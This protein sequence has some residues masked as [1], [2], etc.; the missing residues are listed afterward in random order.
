[1]ADKILKG[2]DIFLYLNN[3]LYNPA[4]GVSYTIDSQDEEIYG[5]DSFYPQEIAPKRGTISG[6]IRGIRTKNSGGLAALGLRPLAA[7]PLKGSYCSIRI[8]DR[9][10][11]EDII[12]IPQCKLTNEQNQVDA[13]GTWKLSFSFK[14][15]V[16]LTSPDRSSGT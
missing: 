10:T 12:F 7:S 6:S 8:R 16:G 13:K 2:A 15:I 4:Q 1:M 5:V 14:G 11:G 9:L 3:K